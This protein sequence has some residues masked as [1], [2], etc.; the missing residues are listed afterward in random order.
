MIFK[1]NNVLIMII[2]IKSLWPEPNLISYEFFCQCS[3][4][5]A[6]LSTQSFIK[7]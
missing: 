3:K 4:L 7:I 2:L 6:I 1:S 5:D